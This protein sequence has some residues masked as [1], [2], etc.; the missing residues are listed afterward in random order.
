VLGVL[1]DSATLGLLGSRNGTTGIFSSDTNTE[2]EP[3]DPRSQIKNVSQVQEK[4][5][6]AEAWPARS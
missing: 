1:G 6:A 2:E 4:V 5:I 3:K